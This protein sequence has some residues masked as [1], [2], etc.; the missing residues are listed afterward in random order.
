MK[1]VVVRD[2]T[3]EHVDSCKSLK[4][5]IETAKLQKGVDAELVKQGWIKT[6]ST[7]SIITQED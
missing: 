3:G 1:W 5:A 6:P 4:M 2:S 7:Y